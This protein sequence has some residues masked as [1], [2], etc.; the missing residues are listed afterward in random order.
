MKRLALML[1]AL[2]MNVQAAT[3]TLNDARTQGRV[4]ETLSGYLAP[5]KQD[6]ETLTL[7]NRIN[8]AR[9]E[10]YQKLADSIN[11]PVDE[12]A[13]MAGQKLVARAQ[14]GEYVKGI[15]GKWLKK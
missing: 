5:I 7:V 12:V 10:S 2:G 13:K 14:P 15:N 4:G 11:L 6:A 8:A 3:L 1:L 9:T